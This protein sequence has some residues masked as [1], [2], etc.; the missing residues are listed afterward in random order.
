MA[1]GGA[2]LADH[3]V[4]ARARQ[5]GGR[6]SVAGHD[7]AEGGRRALDGDMVMANE[8]NDAEGCRRRAWTSESE[9]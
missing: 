7:G 3:A 2:R 6:E 9:H 5:S 4:L 8:A 1:E